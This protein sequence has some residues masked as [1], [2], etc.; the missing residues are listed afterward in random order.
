[1][2]VPLWWGD[3]GSNSGNNNS[4]YRKA[5]GRDASDGTS[6]KLVTCELQISYLATISAS[7][8]CGYFKI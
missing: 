3:L 8:H 7:N 1:M 2:K 5:R 4:N 6:K